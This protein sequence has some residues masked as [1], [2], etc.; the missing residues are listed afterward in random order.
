MDLVASLAAMVV[1]IGVLATLAARLVTRRK[2]A[3]WVWDHSTP[4]GWALIVVGLGLIVA[5]LVIDRGG[6]GMS[7]KLGLGSLLMIA[8]LWMIW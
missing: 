3:L 4:I 6:P 5:G 2:G 8:G 1:G 7:A